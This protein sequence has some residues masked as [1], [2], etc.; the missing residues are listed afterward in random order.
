[1]HESCDDARAHDGQVRPR[2]L[3]IATLAAAL[4]VTLVGCSA[5][6]RGV[7]ELERRAVAPKPHT[8]PPSHPLVTGFQQS[9]ASY[10]DQDAS[11][12][13][14]DTVAISGIDIAA[15]GDA[16]TAPSAAVLGQL[17]RAHRLGKKA[18][19]LLLNEGAHGFSD[20]VAKSML[21]TAAHR[22]AAAASLASVVTQ[23]GFDGVMFDFEELNSDD[24]GDLT[25]FAATLRSD[26]GARIHLDA[27]IQAS[28]SAAGYAG[29]GYDIAGLLRSLDNVTVMGYDQHGS[30]NPSDPG[31]IGELNW[32]KKVL[33]AVL[34]TA[35]PG[36]VD[37]G[38]AGY[39]YRWASD[40]VHTVGDIRARQ[41]VA[42]AGVTPTFDSV[43]GE[44]TATLPDGEVF[45]WSDARSISMREQ[46][47][48]AMGLRGIAVWSLTVSDPLPVAP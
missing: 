4:A 23:Y 10:S 6:P 43:R 42:A 25:A 17:A 9:W 1:M 19:V 30:F 11:K 46:L 2:R 47:A 8:A 16:V 35:T 18:E 20:E 14:L 44:W 32:Q 3:L 7:F 15:G 41:L 22:D 29:L 38:V 26:V 31:P 40:G 21:S 13:A 37:L 39:G 12:A 28:T 33:D 36:Q 27:A 24:A 34:L 48:A 45:W 5:V